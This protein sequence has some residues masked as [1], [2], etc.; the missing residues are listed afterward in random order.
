[1]ILEA[2]ISPPAVTTAAGPILSGGAEVDGHFEGTLG[3]W[4]VDGD[5]GVRAA[6]REG[7]G[8]EPDGAIRWE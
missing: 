2:Q 7:E 5:A 8:I 4:F 6:V 1:M 3:G